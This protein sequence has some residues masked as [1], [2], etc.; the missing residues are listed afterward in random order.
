MSPQQYR[1]DT[2][3]PL[4]VHIRNAA[5]S[6]SVRAEDR[7]DSTVELSPIGGSAAREL[8]ERT[9]VR[10]SP[11]SARLDIE[12]PER[13]FGGGGR[14]AVSVVV[15]TGSTLAV[16]TASADTDCTGT[17]G[18][19]M[20]ASASGDLRTAD[21]HGEVSINTASGDVRVGAVTG[22]TTVRT[23][24]GDIS[25][26]RTDGRCEATTASGDLQVGRAGADV[27][28]K[29]ASGDIRVAEVVAGRVEITTVSGDVSLDVRPGALV[30]LDLVT[31]SGRT[32][33]ALD[34]Q[35]ET[36]A[37]GATLEIAAKTVSGDISI[38]RASLARPSHSEG[39]ST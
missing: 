21:V 5:G 37:T 33:S 2:P 30:W 15:P 9:D 28:A 7:S 32:R 18:G 39:A 10:H 8:V 25:I 24:S 38:G 3:G 6:I 14:V 19:L 31:L 13:R 11:D 12:V 16:R 35:A 27:R 29:S 36:P 20:A 34:E 17:L 26:D 22:A 1:F 4:A 23:A